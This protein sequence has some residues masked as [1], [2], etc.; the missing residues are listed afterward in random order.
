MF[1]FMFPV[2]LCMQKKLPNVRRT[3][4]INFAKML[5]SLWVSMV[6]AKF[7]SHRENTCVDA[8]PGFQG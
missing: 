8:L 2:H 4:H 6:L 3:H 7:S 5:K 1:M